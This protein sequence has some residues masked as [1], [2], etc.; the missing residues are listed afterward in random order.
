M[1]HVKKTIT[2]IQSKKIE[3][4][5]LVRQG[6][7]EGKQLRAYNGRPFVLCGLPLRKPPKD[8]LEHIRHNGKYTLTVQADVRLGLP[9]GQDRIIPII[10]STLAIQRGSPIIHYRSGAE[11]LELIGLPSSGQ[12]YKRVMDGLVRIMGARILFEENGTNY[13]NRE[14]FGY[15][16]R[17]VTW[18]TKRID[19]TTL[20]GLDNTIELSADYWEELKKHPIPVN[21]TAVRKMINAPGMLDLYMWLSYRCKTV[22]D[23]VAVP[24]FG[25]HGL[26]GQL[27]MAEQSPRRLRRSVKAWLA[28]IKP[29]WPEPELPAYLSEDGESLILKHGI[30]I[31]PK[32][33]TIL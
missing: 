15:I 29:F 13:T 24:L 19:Q 17:M 12:S 2:R 20:E 32:H 26:A 10:L 8:K 23:P 33:D 30:N 3:A 25:E 27:G 11:L 22:G 1:E 28:K 18:K 6:S 7:D 21:L 4:V 9:Y 5:E 16:R 14:V 31:L